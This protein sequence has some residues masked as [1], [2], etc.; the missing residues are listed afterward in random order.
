MEDIIRQPAI[1]NHGISCDSN[2]DPSCESNF[3]TPRVSLDSNQSARSESES[4]S[5]EITNIS[6]ENQVSRD[7]SNS[8]RQ[9]SSL[10]QSQNSRGGLKLMDCDGEEDE[11]Y[12]EGF[13]FTRPVNPVRTNT[14]SVWKTMR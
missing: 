6:M 11:D 4:E 2:Q 14:L 12:F 10:D 9:I 7:G 3:R 1:P 8:S 13:P 5:S